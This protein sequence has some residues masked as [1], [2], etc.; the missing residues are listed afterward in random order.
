M[1][2]T[3]EQLKIKGCVVT[4]EPLTKSGEGG[5]KNP[6]SMQEE[7]MSCTVVEQ[8]EVERSV[9]LGNNLGERMGKCS[10]RLQSCVGVGVLLEHDSVV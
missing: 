9:G 10:E 8:K 5:L 6:G 3:P 1:P 4:F 7:D 2:S